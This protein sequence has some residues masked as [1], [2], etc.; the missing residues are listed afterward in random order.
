M[1]RSECALSN[2][3]DHFGDKWSII[4][5]RDMFLQKKTFNDFL[6]SSEGIATNILTNRLKTLD[7]GGV[8]GYR[9]NPQNKKVK[10]YY[11]TDKGVD[12]YPV[13]LEM[14]N[15]SSRNLDKK[16]GAKSIEMFNK[17]KGDFKY[18][19]AKV[20]TSEYLK[21]RDNLFHKSIP[22]MIN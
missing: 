3:L 17:N 7:K 12:S 6:S 10:W 19:F 1:Y 16:F 18:S 2:F 5:I 13:I 8:I 21:F 9:I 14:V 20:K 4:I 11:L 15:W 22:L